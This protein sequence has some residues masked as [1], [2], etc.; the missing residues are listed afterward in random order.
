MSALPRTIRTALAVMTLE[1]P[2]LV[3]QH[4]REGV[5]LDRAGFEENR[6]MRHDLAGKE[7]HVLLTRFPKGLDFELDV[8]TKDHFGPEREEGL[9]RAL[10]VVVEDNLTE[11]IV[12]LAFGYFP[13]TFPV[14]VFTSE[15]EARTWLDGRV[16]TAP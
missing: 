15:Q 16:P 9:L 13:P 14:E 10:A 7:P 5:R 1:R 11:T 8:A 12:R 6:V 2:G 4:F 3:V